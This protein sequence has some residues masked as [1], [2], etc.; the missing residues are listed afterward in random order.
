MYGATGTTSLTGIAQFLVAEHPVRDGHAGG[1]VR[2]APRRPR[3]QGRGGAVPHVDARRVPGRAHADHELHGVRDEDRGVR[4][5]PARVPGRVPALQERLA[6]RRSGSSPRSRSRSAASA[7]RCRPTSSACSPTRRSRTPGYVLMGL[8]AATARGREA[9]LF[10]LFVYTFMVVGSFAVVAV[11]S[12]KGDDDHSIDGY[13]GLGVPTTRARQP[14]H[15]LLPRAGGHP[16]H[17]RV[18]R[19]AGGVLRRD[20]RAGVR[21]GRDRRGGHRGR[22]RSPTCGWCSRSRGPTPPKRKPRSRGGG[23]RADRASGRRLDRSGARGHRG[24]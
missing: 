19:E 24:A 13:R 8:E 12:L 4:R 9:S 10:Y 23:P 18:H 3:L 16:A 15:L 14:A 22:R 11:I 7:P 21:A 2:A 20:R 17:G 5:A 1:R 6:A